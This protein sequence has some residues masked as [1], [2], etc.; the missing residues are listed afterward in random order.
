MKENII[1]IRWHNGW[2][3]NMK[4]EKV[5]NSEWIGEINVGYNIISDKEFI[6]IRGINI[7]GENRVNNR[8][9]GRDGGKIREGVNEIRAKRGEREGGIRG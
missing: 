1:K 4:V 9:K 8:K 3:I 2:W 7:E 5:I 6:R